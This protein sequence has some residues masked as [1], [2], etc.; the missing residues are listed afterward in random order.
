MNLLHS[1]SDFIELYLSIDLPKKEIELI[2]VR[3]FCPLKNDDVLEQTVNSFRK[4]ISNAHKHFIKFRLKSHYALPDKLESL[5]HLSPEEFLLLVGSIRYA[6]TPD[7]LSLILKLPVETITF[8]V[9][10]L[11]KLIQLNDFEIKDIHLRLKPLEKRRF[12]Q[13]QKLKNKFRPQRYLWESFI[14][15][16]SVIFVLWSIPEFKKR[17]E[18]WIEKKTSEYFVSGSIKDAPIPPE[19][20]TKPSIIE[21]E[22]IAAV[23]EQPVSDAT[24]AERKQPKA[25]EGEVWRFSFTGSA[26][27]DLEKELKTFIQKHT[28]QTI[29]SSIAPGGIQYDTLIKVSELIPLK[30]EF[31]SI[32]DSQSHTLKMSWYKKKMATKKV[33]SGQVEVVI[34]ISTI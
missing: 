25:L 16:F 30:I 12:S 8:K 23:E 17:Y 18:K 9:D 10:H 22:V 3:S 7:E 28:T 21:P 27:I 26:K 6:L 1:L 32:A 13:I 24:K 5:L 20:D 2:K 19:L 33:P 34:W 31:E 15:M 29:H 14:I 11:R 4:A